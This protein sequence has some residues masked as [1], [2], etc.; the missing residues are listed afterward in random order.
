MGQSARKE[1]LRAELAEVK[2]R[3]G[4]E[5]PDIT[6]LR[7]MPGYSSSRNKSHSLSDS[8]FLIRIRT[9]MDDLKCVKG[10]TP[11]SAEAL[12]NFPEPIPCRQASQQ[13]FMSGG[14]SPNH[15][16]RTDGRLA[17]NELPSRAE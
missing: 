10:A 5:G 6:W 7:Y 17:A 13:E 16:K 15:G 14:F 1:G 2:T 11:D 12:N 3:A 9:R 8:L 4:P